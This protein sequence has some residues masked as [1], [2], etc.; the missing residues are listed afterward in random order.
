MESQYE[1]CP[2]CGQTGSIPYYYM[3]LIDRVK[4]W[5]SCKEMC[6]KMTAHWRD[7]HHWL[8]DES[9]VGWGWPQKHELWDGTRW[10]EL[11]YFWNPNKAWYLPVRCTFWGCGNIVSAEVMMQSPTKNDGVTREVVCQECGS[12]FEHIPVEVRGDPRNIAYTGM[13]LT[14]G[15]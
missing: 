6:H 13:T 7:K 12:S 2:Y 8:P 15:V 5:C 3:S 10:A 11:S 4:S 14:N 9:R 1:Y